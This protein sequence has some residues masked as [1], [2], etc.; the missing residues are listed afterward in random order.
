MHR[1]DYLGV[2]G[3]KSDHPILSG[4]LEIKICPQKMAGFL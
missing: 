2:S 4:D 1:N 3:Q